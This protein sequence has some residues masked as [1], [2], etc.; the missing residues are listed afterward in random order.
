[1]NIEGGGIE[2]LTPLYGAC[3]CGYT[4]CAEV[5]LDNGAYTYA[6]DQCGDTPLLTA[7]LEMHID[8]VRLLLDRGVNI[9]YKNKHGQTILE[10]AACEAGLKIAD[11]MDSEDDFCLESQMDDDERIEDAIYKLMGHVGDDT[12]P[13]DNWIRDIRRL[14]L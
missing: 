2:G 1:M 4:R 5:L 8:V 7:I 10:R 13:R 6:E 14:W 12:D 11:L 3:F 9:N